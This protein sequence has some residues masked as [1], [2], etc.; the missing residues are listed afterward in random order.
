SWTLLPT[1]PNWAMH[2]TD[3]WT[4]GEKGEQKRLKSFL[5]GDFNQYN[6]MRDRPQPLATSRLS[7]HLHFGEISP[8][9][10]MYAAEEIL[11]QNPKIGKEGETYIRQLGW[12]EFSYYLLYHA[13]NLLDYNFNRK[14]DL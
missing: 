14:F 13:D 3:Y 7:P 6:S 11:H 5:N 2:F 10:V 8:F 1:K 4:P 12:R 9:Q